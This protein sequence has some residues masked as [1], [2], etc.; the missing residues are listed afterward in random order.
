[1]QNT[2][3]G[4]LTR[5]EHLTCHGLFTHHRLHDPHRLAPPEES[6][7][8]VNRNPAH[9]PGNRV[10]IE[11]DE[12][13]RRIH[14][15]VSVE[16]RGIRNGLVLPE[17]PLL[18]GNAN[19]A[20]AGSEKFPDTNVIKCDFH[21]PCTIGTGIIHRDCG[22]IRRFGIVRIADCVGFRRSRQF[23]NRSRFRRNLCQYWWT[24]RAGSRDTGCGWYRGGLDH[25]G[26]Y[27]DIRT[28][29]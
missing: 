19:E 22:I 29:R 14:T 2:R 25:G 5:P 11:P 7:S 12:Y 13:L 15:L 18:T 28:G 23:F 9:I 21:Q 20:P 6:S 10:E 8:Y 16:R 24:G 17:R 1:M 4:Y 26:R 3:D 27:E